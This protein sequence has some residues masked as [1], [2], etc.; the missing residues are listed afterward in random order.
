MK[1][2]LVLAACILMALPFA[3]CADESKT[4]SSS[5]SSKDSSSKVSM[6]GAHKVEKNPDG[7]EHTAD[8]QFET[9]T[10]DCSLYSF[11]F[12]SSLWLAIENPNVDCQLMFK[13]ETTKGSFNMIS[14]TDDQFK[15]IN[16]SE[17]A[18]A[19]KEP[20]ADSE[21]ADFIVDE[22]TTL[23]GLKAYMI[24]VNE[25]K[26]GVD[27]TTTQ[28]MAIKDNNLY[29]VTY[30]AVSDSYN[31]IKEYVEKIISTLKLKEGL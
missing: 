14:V 31:E 26:D 25:P 15:G 4:S 13:D 7:I 6:A 27:T 18:A 21:E 17:Y 9:D 2:I 22:E 23:C 10:F 11:T 29:I 16:V 24:T 1:K 3:G 5:G 28:I 20:Y 30:Y 8:G 19:I 12:D